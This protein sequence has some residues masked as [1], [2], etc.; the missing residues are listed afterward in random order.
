MPELAD[1]YGK[2]FFDDQWSGSLA[3]A[4]VYLGSLMAVWRPASVADLG[5]GR[6]AWLSAA[7]ENG[8][9]RLVG[10]DGE[11]AARDGL[12]SKDIEFHAR[13]LNTA[14]ALGE[15][16][17]LA[18]SLEAA[19]HVRP[20]SSDTFH[21]SLTGLADAVVFSA[22][23]IGQ[24]GTNHINTRPHSFWAAKFLGDGY[25][26]FDYFRPKFW[27]DER[28]E[29][30]YR[31]NTFLYVK[32]THPLSAALIAA[33]EAPAPD[34][35]FVDC[36]HPMFYLSAL[37]EIGRL[38]RALADLGGPAAGRPARQIGRNEPCPG[39]SGKKYKVCHGRT[40]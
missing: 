38:Q 31:Q 21:R 27:A 6:G 7:Q 12:L 15:T 13:D 14:V 18:I 10:I 39:G 24:P 5:C 16:L 9:K 35:R 22:A 37:D 23:F 25:Q 17:D 11:W 1:V 33:G 4:R 19:E 2:S 20:A 32:P 40:A 36:L 30:W 29:P 8:A 34:A 28:V 26:L 3:S